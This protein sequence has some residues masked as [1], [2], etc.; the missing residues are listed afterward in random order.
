MSRV[1]NSRTAMSDKTLKVKLRSPQQRRS[2]SKYAI[3]FE[4]DILKITGKKSAKKR[5]TSP[6]AALPEP[7]HSPSPDR[8]RSR[9]RKKK[10]KKGTKHRSSSSSSL[11][12]LSSVSRS[13]SRSRSSSSSSE[14]VFGKTSRTS[15][16]LKGKK[17]KHKKK[18][19]SSKAPSAFTGENVGYYHMLEDGVNREKR[20][21]KCRTSK[22]EIQFIEHTK[23][24]STTY[25]KRSGSLILAAKELE[26]QTHCHI[27]LHIQPTWPRGKQYRYLSG[28][29]VHPIRS[30]EYADRWVGP[31]MCHV[32]GELSETSKWLNCGH[33]SSRR[34]QG[35]T[36]RVHCH[37]IGVYYSSAIELGQ[38]PFFCPK[39]GRYHKKGMEF[40]DIP[41]EQ[42][43]ESSRTLDIN[44]RPIMERSDAGSVLVRDSNAPLGSEVIHVFDSTTGLRS[45]VRVDSTTASGTEM[46]LHF[47][48][49]IVQSAEMTG[50]PNTAMVLELPNDAKVS[51]DDNVIQT[52]VVTDQSHLDTT[53]ITTS[54]RANRSRRRV[55]ILQQQQQVVVEQMPETVMKTEN[56]YMPGNQQVV[57]IEE[58]QAEEGEPYIETEQVVT[59]QEVEVAAGDDVTDN[60]V[61]VVE[62]VDLQ[63]PNMLQEGEQVV[64]QEVEMDGEYVEVPLPQSHMVVETEQG[65]Q[66]F[67]ANETVHVYVSEAQAE[68]SDNVV[69]QMASSDTDDQHAGE[70][71]EVYTEQAEEQ[72]VVEEN[73][74]VTP[75]KLEKVQMHPDEMIPEEVDAANLP[76][77]TE[78]IHV[79]DSNTAMVLEVQ[80]DG[81]TQ[82]Q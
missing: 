20:A 78:I 5:G 63:D 4:G 17:T 36:Y 28:S 74:N 66:Q 47:H 44:G 37:C 57:N 10:G 81:N 65:Q 82:E 64:V 11:T 75:R 48:S 46:L 23:N 52:Q 22:K 59:M 27:S 35:C 34:K 21:D 54:S 80:S 72:I 31:N 61:V 43:S 9:D 79:V 60:Q 69:F 7:S 56:E 49:S 68:S 40:T 67:A 26:I 33:S 6:V 18:H 71:I 8:G 42:E 2:P 62:Q 25:L 13:R 70:S 39:H 38:V 24:R 77:G 3:D 32:C 58:V 12:S 53:T 29:N 14:E 55:N 1:W 50:D 51:S 73:A 19:K 16:E 76:P 15:G 41:F 45:A 30:A